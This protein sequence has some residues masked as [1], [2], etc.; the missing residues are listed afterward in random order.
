MKKLNEITNLKET[1]KGGSLENLSRDTELFCGADIIISDDPGCPGSNGWSDYVK[2]VTTYAK[3]LS[4]LVFRL[5]DI[6]SGELDYS[7]KYRFYGTLAEKA[8]SV[9][10]KGG[11]SAEDLLLAVIE[12]AETMEI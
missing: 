4:W 8:N 5:K 2:V 1:V 12:T 3:E 9:I 7:N 10:A 6:F 11:H